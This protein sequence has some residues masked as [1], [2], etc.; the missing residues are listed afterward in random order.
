[1]ADVCVRSQWL[2]TMLCVCHGK[3]CE[4]CVRSLTV[5]HALCRLWQG[6]VLQVC[7]FF[8]L[9]GGGMVGWLSLFCS[10]LHH[11]QQ[12]RSAKEKRRWYYANKK[13]RRTHTDSATGQSMICDGTSESPTFTS[14][15]KSDITSFHPESDCLNVL[16]DRAENTRRLQDNSPRKEVWR[17]CRWFS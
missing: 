15:T 5:D 10:A 4:E 11:I 7:D 14:E 1:M 9:G 8:L 6:S 12:R 2:L 3:G 17:F 13:L 16:M